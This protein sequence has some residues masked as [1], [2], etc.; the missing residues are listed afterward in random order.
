GESRLKCCLKTCALTVPTLLIL[1]GAQGQCDQSLQLR[2]DELGWRISGCHKH[3]CL[4][5][6]KLLIGDRLPLYFNLATGFQLF[7]SQASIPIKLLPVSRSSF[8]A[9]NRAKLLP[10]SD[11]RYNC[12]VAGGA[13]QP[14]K[15][16][17]VPD[18]ASKTNISAGTQIKPS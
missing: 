1:R 6:P 18:C 14:S 15:A 11:G 7:W 16:R 12:D 13:G 9:E 17:T 4:D 2:S 3:E 8:G 10:A 5:M